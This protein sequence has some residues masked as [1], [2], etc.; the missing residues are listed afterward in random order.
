MAYEKDPYNFD[1]FEPIPDF[2]MQPAKKAEEDTDTFDPSVYDTLF[3][4]GAV[5][6]PAKRP[7]ESE[8]TP[9][10]A[11]V[12]ASVPEQNQNEPMSVPASVPELNQNEPMSAPASVP[13]QNRNESASAPA[14]GD[15]S[16]PT[17]AA[18]SASE[19]KREEP[20]TTPGSAPAFAPEEWKAT[21]AWKPE[22]A[23]SES[24][25][26]T[27]LEKET[28][29]LT[30]PVLVPFAPP[31]GSQIAPVSAPP[32]ESQTAPVS[33]LP[34]AP[35]AGPSAGLKNSPSKIV[36]VGSAMQSRHL[37]L[38]DMKK[39][40]LIRIYIEED[41]LVPD[42]K[43]DLASILS[44]D[45]SLRMS[46]HELSGGSSGTATLRLTGDLMLQT[47][48]LPDHPGENEP[49]VSIESRIPFK[50]DQEIKAEPYSEVTVI[51]RLESVE[52]TVINERK[53]RV[54]A[55]AAFYVREYRQMDVPLFSG[56][57][58]EEL[59]MLKEK[60]RLT[61]VSRRKTE[62]VELQEELPLKDNAPEIEKILCYDVNVVE[63]HKQINR[64]KAVINAS[65][66][67]NIMYL[68]EQ[69]KEGE[70]LTELCMEPVFYQGK[71]EFTQFIRLDDWDGQT[72][73]G[74]RVWFHP[75]S[76]SVTP[77]EN[78]DGRVN[79]FELSMNVD[80]TVEL[81]CDMET[82]II[83]DVYH[84]GKEIQYDTDQVGLMHLC[85]GGM[86]EASCREIINV[87]E[88]VG[89]VDRVSFLSAYISDVKG[90]IEGGKAAVEGTVTMKA[91]CVGADEKKTPC[92]LKQALPFRC[93]IDVPGARPDMET[94]CDVQLKELWFDKL[95]NRQIEVN[96]GV[97]ANVSVLDQ[98]NHELI[99]N[100]NF[101]ETA[102]EETE[103]PG[104]ILYITRP[105][106]NI[107]KI[108]KRYRTTIDELRAVNNIGAEGGMKPGT[109]LLI[110][111]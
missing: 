36:P 82:E 93:V 84:N 1:Q 76:L 13:E 28:E 20:Q 45:G 41:I 44:M 55:A 32:A 19:P 72:L 7:E 8:P 109:K 96:A 47:L 110:V 22:E 18:P 73:S 59:Q 66:Y 3:T 89:N 5:F 75:T 64:D 87:P 39:K 86:A 102:D 88:Q 99:K 9:I 11:P 33:A 78:E 101:V 48:Y 38:T 12:P 95:N 35:T 79:S 43:P 67:C 2:A 83:S 104:I 34:A 29:A 15:A 108:A 49:I 81:F 31:S 94:D 58:G 106:D 37:S 42:V 90:T 91:I 62:S 25:L 23:E 74:S 14:T 57:Q 52:Y 56:I 65:V 53:F 100:V 68:G 105:G 51:P 17:S 61:D 98:E 46:N 26:G 70:D 69:K 63:N 77:K 80:T 27:D 60:I 4:S 30:E 85:G 107:W 10:S 16:V 111:R 50:E 21:P 24:A 71:T 40:P 92:G 6:K 54:R 103:R 97:V